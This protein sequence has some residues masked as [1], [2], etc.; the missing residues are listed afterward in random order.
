MSFGAKYT[1]T[2]ESV[3]GKIITAKLLKQGHSSGADG[4]RLGKDPLVRQGS[5]RGSDEWAPLRPQVTTLHVHVSE[6]SAVDEIYS[7]DAEWRLRVE[8]DGN[9]D[10]LGDLR[11]GIPTRPD[12]KFATAPFELVSSCGLGQLQDEDFADGSDLY[13]GRR[14]VQGWIME[15]LRKTG[16]GL[17]VATA[18]E[19]YTPDMGSTPNPLEQEY[20]DPKRYV[21]DEGAPWSCYDVLEDLVQGKLA[22][23][24]Q[25]NGRWHCYQRALYRFESFDRWVYPS[26]WADEDASPS[27]QSYSCIEKISDP[28]YTE[29]LSGSEVGGR[30]AVGNVHVDYTYGTLENFLATPIQYD[31]FDLWTDLTAGGDFELHVFDDGA[32]LHLDAPTYDNDDSKTVGEILGSGLSL[33]DSVPV[34]SGLTV[35][36]EMSVEVGLLSTDAET[37]DYLAYVQYQLEGDSGTT[38]YLRRQVTADGEGDYEYSDAEWTTDPGA[39]VA[40]IVTPHATSSPKK[41]SVSIDPPGF[42]EAGRLDYYIHGAIDPDPGLGRSEEYRVWSF[43]T[44]VRNSGHDQ[45]ARRSVT[46]ADGSGGE[47]VDLEMAHGTGPTGAHKAATWIGADASAPLADDWKVGAYDGESDSGRTA[48][49]HLSREAMYQL[50]ARRDVL[51]YA[52]TEEASPSLMRGVD[53]GQARY[54]PVHTRVEVCPRVCGATRAT[55]CQELGATGPSLRVSLQRATVCRRVQLQA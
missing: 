34:Q 50:A 15:L 14:S 37:S 42:P 20:I 48:S 13:S 39:F 29:R 3:A 41:R 47:G 18:S 33:V 30:E 55:V 28:G 36:T 8:V 11:L 10:F 16:L 38:Y 45:R 26:A 17:E 49:E 4:I 21:D 22:M 44:P 7:S 19:W 35:S 54:L 51:L 5:K 23:L 1:S 25:E 32:D 53:K 31:A 46:D 52:F 43:R 24:G 27:A 6:K 12:D 2:F 9:L 40:F